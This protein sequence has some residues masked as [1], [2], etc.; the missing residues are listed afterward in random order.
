MA[1]LSLTEAAASRIREQLEQRGRGLIGREF[2]PGTTTSS[3]RPSRFLV[4]HGS[5]GLICARKCWLIWSMWTPE[6]RKSWPCS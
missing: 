2:V 3:G 6:G 5:E 4:G 1:E